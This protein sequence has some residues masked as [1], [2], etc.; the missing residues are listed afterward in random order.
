MSTAEIRQRIA[1]A[2]TI[3]SLSA[4]AQNIPVVRLLSDALENTRVFLP[5]ELQSPVEDILHVARVQEVQG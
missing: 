1:S 2:D 3:I 4:H 5:A